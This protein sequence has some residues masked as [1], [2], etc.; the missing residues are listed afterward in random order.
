MKNIIFIAPPAAGKGT[1]SELLISKYDYEHIST[2]DLLRNEIKSGSDLGKELDSMMKSGSLI[3]DEI[4]N[5]LLINALSSITKPFILDGYP[6]TISQALKLD[7]ILASLNKSVDVVVYLDVEEEL[8]MKRATGRLSC[9]SCNRIYHK[10]FSK[11][12]VE[13][14]CDDCGSSLISR[15]DD[16]PDTFKVRYDTYMSNTK[17][18]LDFYSNKNILVRVDANKEAKETFSEI[19][20]VI[21]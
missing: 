8:A 11:P 17:P 3:S 16:T 2:G 5:K 19:E 13:G 1:Q 10:Y 21:G 20:K 14:I 4:V 7:E 15:A 18:L 12:K 6:R 9:K